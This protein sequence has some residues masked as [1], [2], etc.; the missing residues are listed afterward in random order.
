MYVKFVAIGKDIFKYK[1]YI[2]TVAMEKAIFKFNFKTPNL[3]YRSEQV[4]LGAVQVLCTL[5]FGVFSDP[6][7]PL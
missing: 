5:I 1:I 3:Y 2:K 6:L 4:I 7:P